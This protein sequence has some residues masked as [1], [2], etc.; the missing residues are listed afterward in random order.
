MRGF[1]LPCAG[2]E[3]WHMHSGKLWS[4]EGHGFTPE[5]QGWWHLLVR[6]A[7]MFRQITDRERH[8]DI[9][10]RT[11]GRVLVAPAQAGGVGRRRGGG[12]P[13]QFL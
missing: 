11:T 4:P 6:Q 2:W 5:C 12:G 10:M 9:A 7:A 1:E 8:L 13:A 3:G